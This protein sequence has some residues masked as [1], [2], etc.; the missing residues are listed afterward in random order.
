[1][2]VLCSFHDDMVFWKKGL[3]KGKWEKGEGRGKE[4]ME[5]MEGMRDFGWGIGREGEGE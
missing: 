3:G 2:D 5:G 1:M 4:G